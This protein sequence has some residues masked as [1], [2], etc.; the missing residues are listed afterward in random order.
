MRKYYYCQKPYMLFKVFQLTWKRKEKKEVNL[1]KR[2]KENYFKV[3]D[4][5]YFCNLMS[6]FYTLYDNEMLY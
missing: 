1:N 2:T 5:K 4:K 3:N 6:S